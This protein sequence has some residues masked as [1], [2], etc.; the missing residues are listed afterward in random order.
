MSAAQKKHQ[1]KCF[2]MLDTSEGAPVAI[3]YINNELNIFFFSNFK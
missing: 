2:V 3:S 1:T